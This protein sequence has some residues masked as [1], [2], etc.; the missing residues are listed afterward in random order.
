MTSE[1]YC[2]AQ[3]C[4]RWFP[5]QL[6]SISHGRD[7]GHVKARR[8]EESGRWRIISA[9]LAEKAAGAF[10]TLTEIPVCSMNLTLVGLSS[11]LRYAVAGFQ[12]GNCGAVIARGWCLLSQVSSL[13]VFWL[14]TEISNLKCGV[15]GFFPIQILRKGYLADKAR[16]RVYSMVVWTENPLYLSTKVVSAISVVK[17]RWPLW[18]YT[19]TTYLPAGSTWLPTPWATEPLLL[20]SP[21]RATR[22][23]RAAPAAVYATGV[24]A[25][26]SSVVS[27]FHIY[28]INH[29]WLFAKLCTSNCEITLFS[30]QVKTYASVSCVLFN[31]SK[32]PCPTAYHSYVVLYLVMYSHNAY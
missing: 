12:L 13:C 16:C 23:A 26:F 20:L 29:Y 10:K 15:H 28:S 19:W 9:I 24:W 32:L 5:L 11:K 6:A 17:V 3:S 18:G 27:W 14:F 8:G 30:T 21:E 2:I 25:E 31:L 1:F 4:T 7:R 22:A